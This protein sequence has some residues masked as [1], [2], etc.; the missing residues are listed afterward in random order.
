VL[1]D[2]IG[3]SANTCEHCLLS[4]Y[5]RC[6]EPVSLDGL[7]PNPN[8]FLGEDSPIDLLTLESTRPIDGYRNFQGWG[9]WETLMKEPLHSAI[10][11]R[12]IVFGHALNCSRLK[13]GDATISEYALSGKSSFR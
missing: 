13:K 11:S 7:G 4:G 2:L 10:L 1:I 9:D 8:P 12:Q 6:L 3:P 5:L